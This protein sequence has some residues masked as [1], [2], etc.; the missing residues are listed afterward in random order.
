MPQSQIFRATLVAGARQARWIAPALAMMLALPTPARSANEIVD[1]PPPEFAGRSITTPAASS[2][3]PG[4]QDEKFLD[5]VAAKFDA[6]EPLVG[7]GVECEDPPLRPFDWMRHWG[8]RH[9]STEGRYIDRG[10]PLEHSSWLNR[11]YHADWFVGPVLMDNTDG[12]RVRQ[13][14]DLFGGLR[15]GWDFDY[16]WGF[17]WRIG[18]SDPHMFAEGYD[19]ELDGNYM[20]SDV[21][22]IYYPWGDTRVRPYFQLGLGVTEIGTV[23]DDGLGQEVFLLSMPFGVG[24]QFP[25]THWLAGRLEILDNLAFGNDGVDT[26]N[27]FSFTAGM[28]VRLGARP[29][30][31]WPWRS[32]RSI[33]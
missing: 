26:M 28:E 4:P 24:V 20:V 19:E 29:N 11:P 1:S 30:S 2:D 17:E 10:V 5:P 6:W 9:S 3:K 8:F 32:S 33:W 21:D 22:F 14:N 18:W 23:N 31:Y 16:Y 7:D 15:L 27:N 12:N 13:A 25:F